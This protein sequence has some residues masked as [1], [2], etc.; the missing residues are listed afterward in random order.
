MDLIVFIIICYVAYRELWGKGKILIYSY[1]KA[2]FTSHV[3]SGS[4]WLQIQCIFISIGI[5][6]LGF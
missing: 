3:K 1:E 4:S 5:A 6:I 2:K